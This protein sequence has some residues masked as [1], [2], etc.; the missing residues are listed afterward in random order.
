MS[1][2]DEKL[3]ALHIATGPNGDRKSPLYGDWFAQSVAFYREAIKQ[4]YTQ[5]Q[6]R[7][8]MGPDNWKAF[9]ELGGPDE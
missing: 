1:A 6:L 3:S 8:F 4:G 7:R 2:L 9:V 5:A